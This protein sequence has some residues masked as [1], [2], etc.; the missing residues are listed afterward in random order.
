MLEFYHDDVA[1]YGLNKKNLA[2]KVMRQDSNFEVEEMEV[3]RGAH[4]TLTSRPKKE[5]I[6]MVALSCLT[7]F[8]KFLRAEKKR[9]TFEKKMNRKLSPRDPHSQQTQI[10]KLMKRKNALQRHRSEINFAS[11][12]ERDEFMVQHDEFYQ[13]A[14]DGQQTV[15]AL[16][17]ELGSSTESLGDSTESDHELKEIEEQPP[18]PPLVQEEI[19]EDHSSEN[20]LEPFC[21]D[22]RNRSQSLE[23]PEIEHKQPNRNM[24][25][26]KSL[27][28]TAGDVT[29]EIVELWKSEM[30]QAQ[31]QEESFYTQFSGIFRE[32]EKADVPTRP[33]TPLWP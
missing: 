23:C 7:K 24:R 26:A 18:P 1:P 30:E 33:K 20:E 32:H 28:A 12:E 3:I 5:K 4:V 25:K 13:A 19:E 27:G 21:F 9:R 6:A 15:A 16:A 14:N 29:A 10:D 31:E 17:Q 22:F 2:D 8:R 11:N